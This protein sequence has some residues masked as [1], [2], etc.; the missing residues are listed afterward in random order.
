M[1]NCKVRFMECPCLRYSSGEPG[2]TS[3]SLGYTI[4][5]RYSTCI[6]PNCGLE[7]IRHK[8]CEDSDATMI[9]RPMIINESLPSEVNYAMPGGIGI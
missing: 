5:K 4:F 2:T 7:E 1:V 3:C 6:S 9:F 8:N